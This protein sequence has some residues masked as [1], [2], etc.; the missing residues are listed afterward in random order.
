MQRW[1]E[2]VLI[3]FFFLHIVDLLKHF[4]LLDKK[5]LSSESESLVVLVKLVQRVNLVKMVVDQTTRQENSNRKSEYTPLF[6]FRMEKSRREKR[7][8][9]C[10]NERKK[11]SRANILLR[12]QSSLTDSELLVEPP[13]KK[14]KKSLFS[15]DVEAVSNVTL[16]DGYQKRASEFHAC[17]KHKSKP[18]M[19]AAIGCHQFYRMFKSPTSKKYMPS[20]TR[21]HSDLQ[22]VLL[23]LHADSHSE[24][25][26]LSKRLLREISSARAYHRHGQYQLAANILEKWKKEGLSLRRVSSVTGY[27][28]STVRFYFT[29]PTGGERKITEADRERVRTFFNRNDVTMVLPHKRYAKCRFLRTAF[30]IQ[31]D[32]YVHHMTAEGFRALSKT[33]VHK[34][35]PRKTYKYAHTIPFQNTLCCKCENF[36]LVIAAGV[37]KGIKGIA[38]RMKETCLVSLCKVET[39]AGQD[40]IL[41]V[42]WDCLARSCKQCKNKLASTL[43]EMNPKL[44]VSNVTHWHQWGPDYIEVKVDGK[45][46]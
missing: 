27:P 9:E 42:P 25:E 6:F 43:A 17:L 12:K 45:L 44:D 37:S 8:Q 35:L 36:H 21:L 4:G 22:K 1:S 34:C 39:V 20:V 19:R 28:F 32:K 33:A 10:A 3:L 5:W 38:K 40:E 13:C 2:K 31:Y 7:G 46:K 30:H 26:L 14:S 41:L 29:Q 15:I 11:R 24:E 18:V 16:P 23:E